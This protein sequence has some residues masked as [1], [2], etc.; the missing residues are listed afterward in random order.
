MHV[1]SA[2]PDDLPVLVERGQRKHRVL[3]E[4]VEV[5][6]AVKP[7]LDFV[8]PANITEGASHNYQQATCSDITSHVS[9]VFNTSVT[10]P[11]CYMFYLLI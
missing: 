3:H 9:T 7:L 4:V 6:L 1:Q 11:H 2:K 10:G 5:D 8:A